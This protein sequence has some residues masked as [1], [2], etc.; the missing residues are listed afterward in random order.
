MQ[1]IESAFQFVPL[2]VEILSVRPS[3]DPKGPSNMLR[4][5]VSQILKDLRGF[6]L[7]PKDEVTC[8]SELAKHSAP[9]IQHSSYQPKGSENQNASFMVISY[10]GYSSH[11]S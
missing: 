5:L 1:R 3:K 11:R 6:L 7:S 9:D 10:R 8:M 4:L 2:A